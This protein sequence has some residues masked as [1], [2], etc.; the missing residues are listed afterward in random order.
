MNLKKYTNPRHY[1]FH[2]K[3]LTFKANVVAL[4]A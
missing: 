2:E 4:A 1:E 3:A